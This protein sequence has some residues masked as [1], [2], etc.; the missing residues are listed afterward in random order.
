M[1][2]KTSEHNLCDITQLSNIH[3]TKTNV[4]DLCFQELVQN[5]FEYFRSDNTFRSIGQ[6]TK[7][8]H[9]P[10][11][12]QS[13]KR[14]RTITIATN[15]IVQWGFCRDDRMPKLIKNNEITNVCF[16]ITRDTNRYDRFGR[17]YHDSWERTCLSTFIGYFFRDS[18]NRIMLVHF[19]L[20]IYPVESI[21]LLSKII[22]SLNGK[23]IME[24][25]Y[26]WILCNTECITIIHLRSD[27]DR[28]IFNCCIE[29]CHELLSSI[30]HFFDICFIS[31]R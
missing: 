13:I 30:R 26:L 25:Q 6:C 22:F 15:S 9:V 17:E 8:S 31:H 19:V 5:M 1:I 7:C 29:F 10:R 20:F 23:V 2:H 16:L 3:I 24:S 27:L 28:S 11:T 21:E 14:Y 12:K 4:I 18:S